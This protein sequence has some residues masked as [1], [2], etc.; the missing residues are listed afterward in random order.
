[1]KTLA[2][3]KESSLSR[4]SEIDNR[5]ELLPNCLKE[6]HMFFESFY[7]AGPVMECI[8]QKMPTLNESSSLSFFKEQVIAKKKYVL[9]GVVIYKVGHM[10]EIVL[11]DE[12]NSSNGVMNIALDNAHSVHAIGCHASD[13]KDTMLNIAKK[14]WT[15]LYIIEA[16]SIYNR[17]ARFERDKLVVRSLYT[18][19]NG[20][21]I[22]LDPVYCEDGLY[23]Y[24]VSNRIFY[25]SSTFN[26][27]HIGTE[28]SLI[29]TYL[30]GFRLDDSK[31]LGRGR[32]PKN[33][34][35]MTLTNEEAIE[36]MKRN[37]V[38]LRV[39][40]IKDLYTWLVGG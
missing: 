15:A 11:C 31:Y 38:N 25:H 35:L 2:P 4:A 36:W 16:Y 28:E 3:N 40:E 20:R 23:R 5:F 22:M 27:S 24:Q 9:V 34:A 6:R 26:I 30:D 10:P 21:R 7:R 12:V 29:L 37:I 18:G 17:F 19:Y 8:V 39:G 13:Y 32:P 1:M 33:K 14:K